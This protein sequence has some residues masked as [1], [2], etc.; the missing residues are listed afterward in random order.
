M[1][2]SCNHPPAQK[3]IHC[4]DIHAWDEKYL[5]DDGTGHKYLPFSLHVH[6]SMY[7]AKVPQKDLPKYQLP[8]PPKYTVDKS[9]TNNHAA[10]PK[11]SCARCMPKNEFLHHQRFRCVDSVVFDTGDIMDRFLEGWRRNGDQQ[12][13]YM[14]GKLER[15][16]ITP[17]SVQ[18][19]VHCI[20]RPLQINSL[21]FVEVDSYPED[22]LTLQYLLQ[23]LDMQVLGIVY[24]DLVQ[25]SDE[26]GNFRVK[27]FR[28]KVILCTI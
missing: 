3:C 28:N 17:F 1:F 8:D 4:L 7:D 5:K 14:V 19:R 11:G 22:D 10:W 24:T 2:K 21:N 16:N 12:I 9:C 20:Y 26:E 27:N 18:A 13:G 6:K 25:D 15:S 23:K